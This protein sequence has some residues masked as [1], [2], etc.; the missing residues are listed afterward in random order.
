MRFIKEIKKKKPEKQN[1]KRINFSPLFFIF[2]ISSSVILSFFCLFIFLP[3]TSFYP[4]NFEK[5]FLYKYL[6]GK[7]V[8]QESPLS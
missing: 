1:K 8:I 3:L 5:C 6:E 7:D 2:S 4:L